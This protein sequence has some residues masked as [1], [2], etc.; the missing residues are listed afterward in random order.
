MNFAAAAESVNGSTVL[1]ARP[2]EPH[3]S[4]SAIATKYCVGLFF[5]LTPYLLHDII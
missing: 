1:M 3:S 2:S 4:Y 5:I